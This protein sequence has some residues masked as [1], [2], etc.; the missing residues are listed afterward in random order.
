[1]TDYIPI[2]CD[3]HSEYELTIM[4]NRRLRISWRDQDGQHHVQALKPR[5]LVTRNHEEF[6]VAENRQ[7]QRQEIRL[8]YIVRTEV[9]QNPRASR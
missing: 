9:V 2:D 6:L 7:G 3:L 5:D 1:M 8:D 4:Q